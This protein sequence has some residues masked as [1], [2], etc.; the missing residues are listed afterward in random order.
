MLSSVFD[1]ELRLIMSGEFSVPL[2]I[3]SPDGS[4]T[5]DT[6]GLFD[7]TSYDVNPETGVSIVTNKPRISIC[8]GLLAPGD[9]ER[10]EQGWLLECADKTYRIRSIENGGDG[11]TILHLKYA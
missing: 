1:E 4:I 9:I 2:Q 3:I 6:Y 7:E 10:I 8:A 11:I 5:I